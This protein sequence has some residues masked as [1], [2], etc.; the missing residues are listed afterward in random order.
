M[1]VNFKLKLLIYYESI[2]F[3]G[4]QNSISII[5]NVQVSTIY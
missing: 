1:M 2:F 5:N 4:F 3:T